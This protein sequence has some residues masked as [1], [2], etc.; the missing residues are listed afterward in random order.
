MPPPQRGAVS[1]PSKGRPSIVLLPPLFCQRAR[2]CRQRVCSLVPC[3]FCVGRD[4]H[5]STRVHEPFLPHTGTLT[6]SWVATCPSINMPPLRLFSSEGWPFDIVLD[7][8]MSAENVQGHLC[9]QSH[10]CLFPRRSLDAWKP[11]AQIP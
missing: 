4:C 7:K 8:M 11:R 6:L 3:G 9:L 10:I 5:P 2:T 1:P